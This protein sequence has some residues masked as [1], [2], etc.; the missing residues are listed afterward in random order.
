[1]SGISK[2]YVFEIKIPLING[3][4]GDLN[5]NH[6]ILQAT[7]TAKGMDGSILQG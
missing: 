3:Q 7:Y 1:M 2:D 6:K 4:V 5:R